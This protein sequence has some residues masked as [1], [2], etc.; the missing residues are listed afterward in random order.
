M[1]LRDSHNVLLQF[2]RFPILRE[3]LRWAS[4]Y[5]LSAIPNG[6]LK[7]AHAGETAF[8]QMSDDDS[9]TMFGNMIASARKSS[10]E[11]TKD[12]LVAEAIVMFVAGTDTT[13]AALAIGLHKLLQHPESYSRLQDEVRT[14]MPTLNSRPLIEELDSLPFLDACIK[15]GLRVSCPSRVRM[16]RTV[17]EEGWKYNGHYLPAGV[18]GSPPLPP[19]AAEKKKE[20]I[21][22]LIL[23][24]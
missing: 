7:L 6:F 15:E 3:A 23:F 17:S 9:W 14:V 13:A 5:N 1:A 10:L 19:L 24:G 4:Y 8:A 11:L 20:K 22:C 16:P 12:H 2:Q 21:R 18:G